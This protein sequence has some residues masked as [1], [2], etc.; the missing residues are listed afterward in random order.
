VLPRLSRLLAAGHGGQILLGQ[1][2]RDLLAGSEILSLR[3]LGPVRMVG[4]AEPEQVYQAI[5]ADLPAAFPPLTT[6]DVRGWTPLPGPP[7]FGRD[8]DLAVLVE[9]LR[10]PRSRLV[11]LVGAGGVGK[12][13][14]AS[15]VAEALLDD[16]PQGVYFIPLAAVRASEQVLSAIAQALG[17]LESPGTPLL[18]SLIARLAT[19]ETLLVLDNFEQVLAAAP[20]VVQ[21]LHGGGSTPLRRSNSHSARQ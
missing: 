2:T 15:Y 21:L 9:Q 14:L 8:R 12:T 16:F 3:D 18:E 11:T 20:L 19:S 6:S 7:P 5:A 1:S 10:G 17:V 13:R 4:L